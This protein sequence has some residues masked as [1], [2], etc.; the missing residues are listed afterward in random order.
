MLHWYRQMQYVV[1]ECGVDSSDWRR[2]GYLIYMAAEL[3]RPSSQVLASACRR[4]FMWALLL[5]AAV[6]LA[7]EAGSSWA[8]LGGA[9]ELG[10]LPFAMSFGGT[11]AFGVLMSAASCQPLR[12]W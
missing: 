11:E 4:G 12:F 3:F 9:R 10:R 7:G 1:L 8:I 6:G 2:H 5:S